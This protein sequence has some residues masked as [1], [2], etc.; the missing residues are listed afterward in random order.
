MSLCRLLKCPASP[1]VRSAPIQ[2]MQRLR[3]LP[4]SGRSFMRTK[5]GRYALGFAVSVE[6]VIE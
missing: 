2:A 4:D 3:A 5:I 6:A 1:N